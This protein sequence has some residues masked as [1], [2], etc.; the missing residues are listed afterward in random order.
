MPQT[1]ATQKNENTLDGRDEPLYQNSGVHD[2]SNGT[3]SSEMDLTEDSNYMEFYEDLPCSG[4]S[5]TSV[6]HKTIGGVQ[7]AM[8]DT[9][10]PGLKKQGDQNVPNI[11][12]LFN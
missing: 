8:V 11:T 9:K 6:P 4:Q 10:S 1:L 5:S 12:P 2:K 7:Y 3:I